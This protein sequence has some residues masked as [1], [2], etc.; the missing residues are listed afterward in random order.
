M[1]ADLTKWEK[2]DSHTGR[3]CFATNTKASS[4]L[5]ALLNCVCDAD[6]SDANASAFDALKS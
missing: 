1:T 5:N 2:Y 6:V 4:N 3:I